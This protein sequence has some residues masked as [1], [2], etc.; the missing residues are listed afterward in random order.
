M[1]GLEIEFRIVIRTASLSLRTNVN[2]GRPA[3]GS[4]MDREVSGCWSY[5]CG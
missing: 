3:T 1:I 2:R 4:D 5:G